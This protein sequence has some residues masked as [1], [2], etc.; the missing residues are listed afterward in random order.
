M[1]WSS[2]P[3]TFMGIITKKT[4]VKFSMNIP[5]QDG[6]TKLSLMLVSGD[7]PDVITV[8]DPGNATKYHFQIGQVRKNVESGRI[9][10][11]IRPKFSLAEKRTLMISKK[12]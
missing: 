10:K 7:I 2:D 5:P 3:N 8:A 11:E 6:A 1:T 12:R 9:D 4:G